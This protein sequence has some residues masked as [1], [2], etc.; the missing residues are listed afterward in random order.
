MSKI[1]CVICECGEA[2][3]R[4]KWDGQPLIEICDACI[5]KA[6]EWLAGRYFHLR[7]IPRPRVLSDDE[8]RILKALK[9]DKF[10][11]ADKI[12]VPEKALINMVGSNLLIMTRCDAK[13]HFRKKQ[14]AG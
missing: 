14:D 3:N 11:P 2:H 9:G 4:M 7:P 13:L 12:G 6:K 1:N 5:V 10:L 8:K